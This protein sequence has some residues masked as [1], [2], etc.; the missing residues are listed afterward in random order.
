MST[1]FC[2]RALLRSKLCNTIIAW[3]AT[4]GKNV[5]FIC[6]VLDLSCVINLSHPPKRVH[7]PQKWWCAQ[8][9][10]EKWAKQPAKGHAEQ[11]V[12]KIHEECQCP[13]QC[14]DVHT[15]VT[16]EAAWINCTHGFWHACGKCC[17]KAS[18][19]FRAT[20]DRMAPLAYLP[21]SIPAYQWAAYPAP[22]PLNVCAIGG[23]M[24]GCCQEHHQ[25]CVEIKAS[26]FL[27]AE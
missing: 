6:H 16:V 22:L 7:T 13:W 15:L 23:W 25:K 5:A 17:G 4:V 11:T 3:G 8:H 12:L 1:I 27:T 20:S 14:Q 9:S 2:I 18:A 19:S 10:S 21:T 26:L 24:F